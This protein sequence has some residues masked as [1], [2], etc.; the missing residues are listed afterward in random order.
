[1]HNQSFS[2]LFKVFDFR[3][4][5]E[6][7]CR[8]IRSLQSLMVLLNL[9]TGELAPST[10]RRSGGQSGVMGLRGIL[11]GT[12]NLKLLSICGQT[13]LLAI[14]LPTN[15]TSIRRRRFSSEI[16]LKCSNRLLYERVFFAIPPANAR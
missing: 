5:R 13:I 4:H 2:R 12:R 10:V 1:M 7:K 14:T 9:A 6:S 11:E 8:S 3:V 16:I 15:T